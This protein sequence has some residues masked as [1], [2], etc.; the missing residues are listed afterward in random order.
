MTSPTNPRILVIDDDPAL[1]EMVA[2]LFSRAGLEPIPALTAA[3]GAEVLRQKPLPDCVLL[4]LMLPDVSGMELLRQIRSKTV[5]DAL[6]IIILSALAD[7]ETIRKGLELGAD[8][9][10][11]KPYLVNNLTRTVFEVLRDGR[12]QS[13]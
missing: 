13:S 7:P 5:F 4:D 8:R 9:Y 11:T 3:E 6:P 12:R 1:Q 10:L 2:K